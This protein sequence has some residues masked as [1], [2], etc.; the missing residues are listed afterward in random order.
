[1][2]QEEVVYVINSSQDEF[3]TLTKRELYQAA[4]NHQKTIEVA[5]VPYEGNCSVRY[6][7]FMLGGMFL[8]M[9]GL[10]AWFFAPGWSVSAP[11]ASRE[12]IE[13]GKELFNHVWVANDPIGRQRSHRWR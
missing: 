10:G 9:V 8:A 2:F 4:L 3:H 7:W 12:S 13:L 6:R 1:M 5:E 11:T